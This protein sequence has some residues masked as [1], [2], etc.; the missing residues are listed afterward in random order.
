LRRLRLIGAAVCL[1]LAT[2]ASAQSAADDAVRRLRLIDLDG[3]EWTA[4]RLRGRVT[5]VDFWAT[6]CAPC[7]KELPYIKQARARY[8][9]EE[10]EVLGVSFDATD[11]RTFVSWLNRQ[12]VTWPQVFDGRGRR[13]DAAREF[14]VTAV[15]TSFLVDPSGRIV[16]R[17]LRGQRLLAAIEAHVTAARQTRLKGQGERGKG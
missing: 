1:M 17:N 14:R 16:A 8:S 6:W 13:G 3:R 4:E 10:F 9:R 5:L 2:S 11:R 15:P 12:R 7:L